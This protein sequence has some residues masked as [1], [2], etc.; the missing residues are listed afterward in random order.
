MDD[1][2]VPSAAATFNTDAFGASHINQ[3][4][5]GGGRQGTG[6]TAST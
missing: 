5:A 3:D 1:V 2:A 4:L 6:R